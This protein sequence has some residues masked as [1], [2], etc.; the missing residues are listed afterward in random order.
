M[1]IVHCFSSERKHIN[2]TIQRGS[3][4]RTL[5]AQRTLFSKDVFYF[6]G[7]ASVLLKLKH[8]FKHIINS[9]FSCWRLTCLN[10]GNMCDVVALSTGTIR[11]VFKYNLRVWYN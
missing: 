3:D 2:H 6:F 1:T 9:R 10:S 4:G 5:I 7:G 8:A 11:K